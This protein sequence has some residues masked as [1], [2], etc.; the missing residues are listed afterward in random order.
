MP[1][2]YSKAGQFVDYS[3]RAVGVGQGA[4][5]TFRVLYRPAIRPLSACPKM[6]GLY[7]AGERKSVPALHGCH[8]LRFARQSWQYLGHRRAEDSNV[9]LR[10]HLRHV[11]VIVS[12]GWCFA[13]HSW[14]Q[15]GQCCTA[16]G[17]ENVL[18]HILHVLVIIPGLR[19]IVLVLC[20]TGAHYTAEAGRCP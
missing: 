18:P 15:S 20:F 3:T 7:C 14:Q 2:V 16:S 12:T 9:K 13:R 4:S 1:D 10:P 6:A 19:F 11:L 17:R 8:R 5:V